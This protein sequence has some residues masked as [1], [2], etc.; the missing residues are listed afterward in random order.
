MSKELLAAAL[1]R[2]LR[3]F[4]QTLVAAIAVGAGF[5]DVD[6]LRLVSV[7]GVAALVSFLTSIVAGLPEVDDA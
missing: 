4:C 3:T 5:S 6:W 2:A 1:W 7:A